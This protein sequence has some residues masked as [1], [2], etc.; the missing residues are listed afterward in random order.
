MNWAF[1]PLFLRFQTLISK[2][3]FGKTSKIKYFLLSKMFDE[4]FA[5]KPAIFFFSNPVTDVYVLHHNSHLE[6]II[7]T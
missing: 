6:I 5:V 4:F 7:L 3:S 2:V 1:A